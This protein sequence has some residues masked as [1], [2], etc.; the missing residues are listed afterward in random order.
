MDTYYIIGVTKVGNNSESEISEYLVN[1]DGNTQYGKR[2]SKQAFWSQV[3]YTYNKARFYCFNT[4]NN[5]N[6]KRE[7][8]W[9]FDTDVPYLKT[10]PNG[11]EKDNL[12][13]LP[14]IAKE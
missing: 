4:L 10:E 2:Y 3:Q 1:Q 7:C 13:S 6:T 11:T 5:P 12:L 8:F 14:G 9:Q